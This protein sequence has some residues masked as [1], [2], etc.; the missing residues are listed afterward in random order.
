MDETIGY[1]EIR[2]WSMTKE[3]K[4]IDNLIHLVPLQLILSV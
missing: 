4:S 1:H 3:G 2:P